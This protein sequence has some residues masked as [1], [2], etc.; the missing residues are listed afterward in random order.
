MILKILLQKFYVVTTVKQNLY[1]NNCLFL[2]FCRY[3]RYIKMDFRTKRR[4]K[5]S[6]CS[7]KYQSHLLNKA[8]D[9]E[10]AKETESL[11]SDKPPSEMFGPN[12]EEEQ[13]RV[14]N[15]AE[16]PDPEK[17][18]YPLKFHD[19]PKNSNEIKETNELDNY[20]YEKMCNEFCE[21]LGL[22]FDKEADEVLFEEQE[23]PYLDSSDSESDSDGEDNDFDLTD[24]LRCV[25]RNMNRDVLTELLKIL[26]DAGHK[27]YRTL[28]SNF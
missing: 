21:S 20:L 7:E 9:Q 28:Q 5:F 17:M 15:D 22:N 8:L 27:E 12:N 3:I 6:D 26:Q 2:V 1:I 19:E 11:K 16:M 14:F 23:Y 25:G 13:N 10:L 18:K 24:K 4:K